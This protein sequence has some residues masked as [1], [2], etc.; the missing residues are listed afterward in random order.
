MDSNTHEV[1]TANWKGIV[2]QCQSRPE[3]QTI[4]NWCEQNNVNLNTYY[5]WQRRVRRAVY[6]EMT[7]ALSSAP[8]SQEVSVSFAEIPVY[9]NA[10]VH[11]AN[12]PFQG[13][14]PDVVICKGNILVGVTNN[15]SCR[16]LD[17]I[18]E[19]MNHVG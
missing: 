12:N 6:Q 19:K 2:A 9:P 16:V 18:M 17:R 15:V 11:A 14:S 4:A 10:D 13:F 5:Y 8:G 1:R 7:T 3:G